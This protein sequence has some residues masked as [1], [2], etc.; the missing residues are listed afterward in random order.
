MNG[1]L[2]LHGVAGANA[3]AFVERSLTLQIPSA[4]E[5]HRG[6]AGANAP[7]FVERQVGRRAERST[8]GP[9]CRRG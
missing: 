2:E 4:G 1:G 5:R 3:P 9:E 6:V 7:A 8:N